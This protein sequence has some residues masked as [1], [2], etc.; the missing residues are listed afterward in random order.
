MYIYNHVDAA[1][2]LYY[3]ILKNYETQV[4]DEIFVR[5]LNDDVDGEDNSHEATL[6]LL[7]AVLTNDPSAFLSAKTSNVNRKFL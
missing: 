2:E 3:S 7:A 6:P 1:T 5:R 4:N